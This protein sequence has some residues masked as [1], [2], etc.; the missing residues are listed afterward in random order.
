LL[1]KTLLD[2]EAYEYHLEREKK[3]EREREEKIQKQYEE[4]L[5]AA[6]RWKEEGSTVKLPEDFPHSYPKPPEKMITADVKGQKMADSIPNAPA[7][8]DKK[9]ELI[10]NINEAKKMKKEEFIDAVKSGGKWDYKI[11]DPK[12][13]DFGNYN[14]GVTAK[15]FASKLPYTIFPEE[16]RENVILR[17]AGYYQQKDVNERPQLKKYGSP[18][19]PPPYGDEEEDQTQIKSGIEYYNYLK[20]KG[21]L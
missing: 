6:R 14:F 20:S 7:V 15:A 9:D 21:L 3:L 16:L 11:Q 10:K 2:P 4:I 5:E 19:G 17:G 8:I 12:L 18:L 13:E 1:T